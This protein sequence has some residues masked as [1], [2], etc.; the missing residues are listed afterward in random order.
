MSKGK[1][2]VIGVAVLVG[3]PIVIAGMVGGVRQS[4]SSQ[5]TAAQVGQTTSAMTSV[6]TGATASPTTPAAPPATASPASAAS[7][8]VTYL[9]E[10]DH[11]GHSRTA[12]AAL[13]AGL[14]R[15]CSDDPLVLSFAA[16]DTAVA[17]TGRLVGQ[18]T[19]DTYRVLSQLQRNVHATS[20]AVC[21]PRLSVIPGQLAPTRPTASPTRTVRPAPTRHTPVVHPT[22]PA[23][24]HTSAPANPPVILSP[25]GNYYRAGQ[26]CPTRDA[27]LS[28]VDANGTVITC[29]MES[30]R[31]HWHY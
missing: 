29:G 17:T 14:A 12:D 13:L 10:V 5:P 31:Y 28:T 30:G 24:Q 6:T 23:V 19:A 9:Y 11:R 25:S 4:L 27:G 7:K 18:G 15:H 8:A 3:A 2:I 16:T 21:R 1:K 20:G 26:F 22:T